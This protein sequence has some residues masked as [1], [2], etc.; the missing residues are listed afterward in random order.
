M[1]LITLGYTRTA[2]VKFAGLNF[3][4]LKPV[5]FSISAYL[6]LLFASFYIF[7]HFFFLN[8]LVYEK[9]EICRMK[10]RPLRGG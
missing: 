1:S 10:L 3:F 7:L 5:L 9:S 2:L 6:L 4:F 8:L